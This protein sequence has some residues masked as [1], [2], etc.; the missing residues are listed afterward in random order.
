MLM[1]TS[2]LMFS[3]QFNDISLNN[4]KA[5]YQNA[6]EQMFSLFLF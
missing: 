1:Q 4:L 3:N 5:Y 6:P 2:L